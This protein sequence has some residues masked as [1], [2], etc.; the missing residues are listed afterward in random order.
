M[1]INKRFQIESRSEDGKDGEDK[2]WD[3][4]VLHNYFKPSKFIKKSS[5]L[6]LKEGNVQGQQRAQLGNVCRGSTGVLRHIR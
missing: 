1:F 6:Y 2:M 4:V 5:I 3:E